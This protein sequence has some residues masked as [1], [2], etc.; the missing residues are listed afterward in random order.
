MCIPIILTRLGWAWWWDTA[1]RRWTAHRRTHDRRNSYSLLRWR[2]RRT[3]LLLLLCSLPNRSLILRLLTPTDNRRL[4]LTHLRQIPQHLLHARPIQHPCP[5]PQIR[6]VHP[7]IHSD[8]LSWPDDHVGARCDVDNWSFLRIGLWNP[9]F[10]GKVV[11]CTSKGYGERAR[12]CEEEGRG[13][14]L[15]GVD[16]GSWGERWVCVK[17]TRGGGVG[18]LRIEIALSTMLA[19]PC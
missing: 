10:E 6:V 7:P 16:F 14:V 11:G 13:A 1:S 19:C 15:V 5:I 2:L 8:V 12:Q 9:Y 4:P 3:G 17:G 18:P